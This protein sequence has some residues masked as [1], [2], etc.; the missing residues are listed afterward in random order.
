MI[1]TS[2][3]A[4]LRLPLLP[5]PYHTRRVRISQ[6]CCA[7]WAARRKRM[8][9]CAL[10]RRVHQRLHE[11]HSSR[12]RQSAAPRPCGGSERPRKRAPRLALAPGQQA[13][14]PNL[15]Q[16][17]PPPPPGGR[18]RRRRQAKRQHCAGN[19]SEEQAAQRRRHRS[20]RFLRRCRSPRR[21]RGRGRAPRRRPAA[22]RERPGRRS[23]RWAARV[24][25]NVLSYSYVRSF[26]VKKR[27][28]EWSTA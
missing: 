20:R 16:R 21:E 18:R 28:A 11:S 15:L 19:D 12:A 3:R 27:G 7:R 17:D 23:R 2:H 13:P 14:R 1:D 8:L 24:A 22:A 10:R 4:T 25:S 9:C 6:R 5:P 26:I